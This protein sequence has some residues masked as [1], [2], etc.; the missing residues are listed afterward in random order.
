MICKF[1][2]KKFLGRKGQKYCSRICGQEAYKEKMRVN[3]VGKR[4]DYCKTCGKQLPKNKSFYC[5][6]RCR[7]LFY[8]QGK[9]RILKKCPICSKE[10][11][12]TNSQKKF[13]S[14]DCKKLQ[15][16][17]KDRKRYEKSN[18]TRMTAEEYIKYRHNQSEQRK[19]NKEIEDIWIKAFS[20]DE[21]IC[22][23]CGEKFYCS[24]KSYQKTC[25]KE[26][27][28]KHSN[29]VRDKRIKDI[30]IDQDISL[31]RLYKRDNGLCYLCGGRCSYNDYREA[32]NGNPYPGD[33]YPTIEHV[34]PISRGGLHSWDNVRLACWKCNIEKSD[35]IIEVIPMNSKMAY[36]VKAKVQK[37]AP[38]R[39]L[40]LSKDGEILRIWNSTAEVRRELGINDKH[41]QD[42]CRGRLKSAY[43]YI[44]KYA[45]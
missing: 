16:K 10:F 4:L 39:T 22:L 21:R 33:K 37:N 28:S 3:Y 40:Q 35:D 42:V 20:T 29:R 19:K 36:S 27:S 12:T 9:H 1:C 45:E 44:W 25:S 17:E 8:Y 24:K 14:D 15:R 23:E 5:S 18:P 7:K 38:K 34:I 30:T 43:G 2:A 26:C 31:T 32:K 41:I 13:C 6:A 11:E